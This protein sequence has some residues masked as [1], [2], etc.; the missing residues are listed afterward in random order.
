MTITLATSGDH[1][2]LKPCGYL[3][4]TSYWMGRYD[5][6]AELQEK[7]LDLRIMFYGPRHVESLD[8]NFQG[9]LTYCTQ[10]RLGAAA[11]PV[12]GATATTKGFIEHC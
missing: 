11:S 7:I 1:R 8:A 4:S 9:C 10:Q 5:E 6:A 2:V 12:D 3:A